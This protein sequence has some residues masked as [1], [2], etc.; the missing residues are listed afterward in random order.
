MIIPG[1]FYVFTFSAAFPEKI[2]KKTGTIVQINK[3]GFSDDSV[4][5]CG[6]G[7]WCARVTAKNPTI[8][9]YV[10]AKS[11]IKVSKRNSF[12]LPNPSSP[13]LFHASFLLPSALRLPPVFVSCEQRQR[14]IILSGNAIGP[15]GAEAILLALGGAEGGV[16]R[17]GRDRGSADGEGAGEQEAWWYTVRGHGSKLH[18]CV[19][20]TEDFF[21]FASVSRSL[22]PGQPASRKYMITGSRYGGGQVISN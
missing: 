21:C 4:V 5:G 15:H 9:S 13:P 16:S 17:E 2:M 7:V 20:F 18:C 8:K 14:H 3:R 22:L 11:W 12:L 10:G 19:C 1:Y 6:S